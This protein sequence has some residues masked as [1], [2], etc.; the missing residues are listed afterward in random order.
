MV[1]L[2]STELVYLCVQPQALARIRPTILREENSMSPSSE[3]FLCV[4]TYEKG[5]D[6]LRQLA[7]LGIKVTLLTVE[8][9]R[10]G[11]WPHDILEDLAIMPDGLTNEQVLNTVSWMFRGRT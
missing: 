8:K 9:H 5:Q 10:H 2:S 1:E 4:S 6:F 3:R 11:D 7:E